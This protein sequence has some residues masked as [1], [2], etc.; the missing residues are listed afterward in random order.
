[1]KTVIKRSTKIS[2]RLLGILACTLTSACSNF[3]TKVDEGRAHRTVFDDRLPSG[4]EDVFKTCHNPLTL[5]GGMTSYDMMQDCTYDDFDTGS[6]AQL[7]FIGFM[8]DPV[9][10]FPVP[11]DDNIYSES[12]SFSDFPWPM[13]GCTISYNFDVTLDK[14]KLYNP[15]VRWTS[16]TT[17][18][19]AHAKAKPTLKLSV[20]TNGS[21]KIGGANITYRINCPSTINEA[22]VRT[23]LPEK[24][25][26]IYLNDLS[27]DVKMIFKKSSGDIATELQVDVDLDSISTGNAILNLVA[28]S[29]TIM[30]N[31]K[32][33]I[34]SRIQSS[35]SMLPDT[36][37]GYMK[38]ALPEDEVICSVDYVDGSLSIKTAPTATSCFSI[39]A[40]SMSTL[41]Y[42]GH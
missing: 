41:P 35:L 2:I 12:S 15:D 34:A 25:Y 11:L 7:V 13:Q 31:M 16:V 19:G 30:D 21:Q 4:M 27:V 26:D 22:Y 33:T 38:G 36:I 3:A 40:Q 18:T 28:N 23:F 9:Y 37:L 42:F 8:F 32:L 24:T 10:E 17:S 1:M 39:T 29:E 14:I 5:E 20:D 6:A